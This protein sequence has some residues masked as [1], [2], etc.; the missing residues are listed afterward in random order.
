MPKKPIN[1]NGLC[2]EDCPFFRMLDANDLNA[3]CKLHLTRL[4]Y[5][6]G[7]HAL[8]LLPLVKIAQI[9]SENTQDDITEIIARANNSITGG[10]TPYRECT[11]SGG[12]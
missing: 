4:D 6:D 12:H 5:Y 3:V 2:A 7:F 10:G 1:C 11:G 8:C 9:R